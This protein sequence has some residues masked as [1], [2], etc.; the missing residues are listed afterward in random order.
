MPQTGSDTLLPEE[1]DPKQY[2]KLSVSQIFSVIISAVDGAGWA[3]IIK[4]FLLGLPVALTPPGWV[5]LLILGGAGLF[6]GFMNAY[7][8]YKELTKLNDNIRST[9]GAIKAQESACAEKEKTIREWRHM[10]LSS[11]RRLEILDKKISQKI[12][13]IKHI[14][15]ALRNKKIITDANWEENLNK[16]LDRIFRATK[17]Q[18]ESQV[19]E[20]KSETKEPRWKRGIKS[21]FRF[22]R[23]WVQNFFPGFL[24]GSGVAAG[25]MGLVK[26]LQSFHIAG[27]IIIAA[28][29]LLTSISAFLAKR[30]GERSRNYT[31]NKL[32][33]RRDMLNTEFTNLQATR[34]K[35]IRYDL[36]VAY[37]DSLRS[38][39]ARNG[40]LELINPNLKPSPTTQTE[41]PQNKLEK[42][43]EHHTRAIQHL[44]T[45]RMNASTLSEPNK[46]PI[47][48]EDTQSTNIKA[49]KEKAA[50]HEQL[51]DRL[52][53]RKTLS[54]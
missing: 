4:L 19:E 30:F 29:G 43:I 41:K 2:E 23:G 13:D 20:E 44:Q 48:I 52:N 40:A 25:I 46:Q 45:K 26:P 54:L 14:F 17:N 16:Q 37:E 42:F 12:N 36:L 18:E 7:N 53:T 15:Q 33:H 49:L 6:F 47:N 50:R 9:I 31:L 35:Q 3:F 27:S 39:I 21:A 32:N 24:M 1:L 22:V 38:R 34:Q 10:N 51:I 11:S 8:K 5:L 28:T